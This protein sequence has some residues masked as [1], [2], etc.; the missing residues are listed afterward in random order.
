M[1]CETLLG[2]V[3]SSSQHWEHICFRVFGKLQS[4]RRIMIG[5]TIIYPML[6]SLLVD[7]ISSFRFHLVAISPTY[8]CHTKAGV[9]PSTSILR[10][11]SEG[12][13]LYA[14]G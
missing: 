8:A 6:G 11:P 12:L 9:L 14:D 13:Y 2:Q 3:S 7:I 1:N 4:G 10:V 5:E